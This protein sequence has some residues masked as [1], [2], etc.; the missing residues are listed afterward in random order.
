ME[1]LDDRVA[2]RLAEIR[3]QE[4]A[5]DGGSVEQAR[6]VEEQVPP[7]DDLGAAVVR[8][9]QGRPIR[10]FL[11]MVTLFLVAAG[12]FGLGVTLNR[13]AGEDMADARRTGQASVRSCVEHGP[14]TNR[15]FGYWESC[16]VRV[17]WSDGEAESMT[18]GA[19]F[20]AADI[21]SEVEVGDLGRYRGDRQLARAD[22][23]SRSWLAWLGYGV[24]LLGLAPALI[25][26]LLMRQVLTFRRR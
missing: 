17:S 3:E 11:F 23:P 26:V 9:R 22:E 15:G 6:P 4:R 19:V 5:L 16:E 14:V 1:P 21:G 18:V 7:A 8:R 24:G 12:L 2:R 13:W 25:W 20:T 10:S